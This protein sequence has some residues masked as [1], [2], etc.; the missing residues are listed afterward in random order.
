MRGFSVY[1]CPVKLSVLFW[2]T[3]P[4][5]RSTKWH[6]RQLPC[7][8]HGVQYANPC[9]CSGVNDVQLSIYCLH[10]ILHQMHSVL[11][12]RLHCLCLKHANQTNMFHVQNLDACSTCP[13]P[14]PLKTA[15]TASRSVNGESR[16]TKAFIFQLHIP[17]CS[18]GSK[19]NT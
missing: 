9:R 12:H 10:A 7:V 19:H 17:P 18:S 5:P 8:R 16:P 15:V 13:K 6:C 14:K 4:K 1:I 11:Q 3:H 2:A